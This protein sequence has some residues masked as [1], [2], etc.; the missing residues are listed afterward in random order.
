MNGLEALF[1]NGGA[2]AQLVRLLF[3]MLRTGGALIA[4]P[5]FGAVGVPVQVRTLLAGAV[6]LLVLGV[7]PF[8]VP[9]DPLSFLGVEIIVQEAI[10]GL[11]L[12]FL[13]QVAFAAPLLAGEYLANSIGLGFAS[14]VDP[15]GGHSSPV[16]SQFLMLLMTLIFLSLDGHLILMEVIVRS[17]QLLPPGGGWLARGQLWDVVKFGGF[18]FA[19]GLAIALPVGFALFA[20][21]VVVGVVTRTAPQLN[22]FAVGLPLTLIA[23]FVVFAIAFPTMAQ[24]MTGAA[25]TGI[26]MMRLLLA[27]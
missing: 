24:L 14:M 1:A 8:T 6:G 21:N 16:V 26:D 17:Y 12:G 25:E 20:L 9:A 2:E 15:Q 5:V 27:R 3:A 22:I 18:V 7:H 19:S 23:G 4:A 13:L 10:I 11:T